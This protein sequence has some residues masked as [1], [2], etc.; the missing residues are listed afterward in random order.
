[1]HNIYRFKCSSPTKNK[2]CCH[3]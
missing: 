3:F 2:H 1:M